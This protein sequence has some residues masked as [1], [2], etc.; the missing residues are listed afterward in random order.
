M[1]CAAFCR[2]YAV[3]HLCKYFLAYLFSQLLTASNRRT[4]LSKSS[5]SKVAFAHDSQ[6]WISGYGEA[7]LHFLKSNQI[8]SRL[9]TKQTFVGDSSGIALVPSL[10]IRSTQTDKL[11]R[12]AHRLILRLD[13]TSNLLLMAPES[14]I[15]VGF[16]SASKAEKR[17]SWLEWQW[18]KVVFLKEGL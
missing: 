16:L 10:L 15:R 3:D 5:I 8:L 4:N 14:G 7:I 17:C 2:S 9:W 11:P 18:K 1:K 13:A 12:F 6:E